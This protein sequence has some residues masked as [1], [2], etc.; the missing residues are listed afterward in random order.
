MYSQDFYFYNGKI[1]KSGV[2][3]KDVKLFASKAS[4]A[5]E[6]DRNRYSTTFARED[7]EYVYFKLFVEEPREETVI[8]IFLKITRMED[9]SVFYDK[10][11]L[12]RLEANTCACWN[13][14]GFNHKGKWNIGLYKYSLHVGTGPVYE[15]IF[16]VY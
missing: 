15:G 4:G 10:Y 14:I 1:K 12:H 16:T 8:Q 7:L 2:P 5:L 3:V 11:I 9:N 13:G 6:A